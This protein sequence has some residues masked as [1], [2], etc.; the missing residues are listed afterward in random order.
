MG[1][2]SQEAVDIVEEIYSSPCS[3]FAVVLDVY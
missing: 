2:G 3:K 1:A